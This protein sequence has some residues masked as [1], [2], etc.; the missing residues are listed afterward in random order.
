MNSSYSIWLISHRESDM[1]L[2]LSKLKHNTVHWF[3]GANYPSFSQLVNDCV[4]QSPTETTIV[5]CNK[6]APTDQNIEL[7]LQ[8]LDEG[9]AFVALY[10]FRFFGFKKE[11]F[12]RI[13]C[14][15]E[16]FPGGFEDDDF[17]LRLVGSNLACYITQEAEH[18]WAPSSWAPTGQYPGVS[19]FHEKWVG[20]PNS[21][22]PTEMY[23]RLPNSWA[24]RDWGPSQPCEFL[25]CKEHSYVQTWLCKYFYLNQVK[26][27]CSFSEKN[28]YYPPIGQKH[29]K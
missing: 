24:P 10:D 27:I 3:N 2:A 6:V 19:Y 11:L 26:K 16:K 18:H 23:Q 5:L 13:G 29:F 20:W 28:K 14:L 15:D 7:M 1:E 17:V 9:Y 25:T 22:N 21:E 12:R 4:H 8:K